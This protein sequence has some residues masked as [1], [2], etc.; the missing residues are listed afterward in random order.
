MKRL[1]SAAAVVAL[2]VISAESSRADIV[3]IADAPYPAGAEVFT[4][5]PYERGLPDPAGRGVA[6]DRHIRQT[7]QNPVTFDVQGIV[8][9]QDVANGDLG[10]VMS[11]YEVD[12]VNAAEFV[13]G[14]LITTLTIPAGPGSLPLTS[15]HRL[16]FSLSGA[17]VFTL[18]AR[19]TAN[20]TLGYG[21][22][23][24]NAMGD[25]DTSFN[26][27]N[28]RHTNDGV[29]HYPFGAHYKEGDPG[30]ISRADRDFGLALSSQPVV[31]EPASIMLMTIAASALALGRKR[32]N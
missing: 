31:P 21:F 4:V 22:E 17:D 24:S 23:I 14:N 10:Y 32:L 1:I 9:S 18:P 19:G 13:P 15:D 11:V 5:D 2:L 25:P 12:D 20:D 8:I 7:F 30:P 26:I 6:G 28:V 29:D 27:G 16:G 3:A